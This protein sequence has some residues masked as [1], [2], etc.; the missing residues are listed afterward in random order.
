MDIGGKGRVGG[1]GTEI[2]IYM[3]PCVKQIVGTCYKY[4]AQE[5]Q[6]GAL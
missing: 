5:P 2:N 6:L 3:L 4:K 1:I